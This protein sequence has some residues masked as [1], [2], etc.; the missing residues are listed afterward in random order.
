MS[1]DN[2]DAA[3]PQAVGPYRQFAAAG[4]LVF[5]SGQIPL[6]PASGELVDGS[7]A[8]AT[9][10]VLRNLSAVL[11]SAGC[12]LASVV[13]TTIFLVDMADF[14]AVNEIYAH[15]FSPPYPARACVAVAELPKGA[16]VEI[17]AVARQNRS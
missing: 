15:Y 3:L 16:R 10:Q 2:R 1:D 4:E 11:E 5:V 8:E 9:H 14:T 17:E 6:N 13:K 7:I 12:S